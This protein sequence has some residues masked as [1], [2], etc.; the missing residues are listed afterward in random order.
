MRHKLRIHYDNGNDFSDPCLWV[1]VTDGSTLEKELGPGGKDN[2]GVYYDFEFNRSSFN[3]K[4]KDGRGKK[5]LWEDDNLNRYY[6]LQLGREIWTKSDRHNVY[7]VLPA[8]PVG[9][10]KDYYSGI[11]HLIPAP[12]P[13]R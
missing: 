13:Q 7:H 8:E 3:F 2:Y 4:F 5:A 12:V 11:K 1:W 10:V 9:H 6:D